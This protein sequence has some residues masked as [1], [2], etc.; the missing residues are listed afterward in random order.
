MI[1]PLRISFDVSCSVEHA[2]AVW[3]SAIGTWWPADHTVSGRPDSV[4]LEAGAGGRIYERAP[5][6]NEHDWGE[7][8]VWEPPT[9]LG[10]LWHLNRDPDSATEVDIRF[11]G[12]ESVTTRIDIEHR[13]W[14]R[15]GDDGQDWRD[16]NGAGWETLLPHY[17][18]AVEGR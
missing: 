16:R 14:E 12:V 8:T 2:F 3:T 15:L 6:G 9:H 10:Y 4:V 1:A 11:S 18:A 7:V 17:L 5:D 13:G